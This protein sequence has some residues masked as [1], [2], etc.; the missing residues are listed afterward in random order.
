MSS[1]RRFHW[2]RLQHPLPHPGLAR[3]ARRRR[4]RR[5][6]PQPQER[7]GPRPSSPAS[8]TSALP[9]PTRASRR[10]SPTPPSTPSGSAAPTTPASRTSR[11]SSTPSAAAR[12]RSRASPAR[13][14]SPAT[15]PRRRQCHRARRVGRPQARLPREPA[16]RAARLAGRSL[17]W[18][19]GAATTGRPYL[20]RAAEEHSGPHAPWFWQGAQQGGGVLNDM[21]CHSALVVRHLLT[22]PAKPLSTVRAARITAHIASL[23][24][25]RPE[26]AKRS[27]TMGRT[28]TTR[29]RRP[30]TSR[31]DDRVRDRRR[32]QGDRRGDH[33]LELRG[34]RAAP[35]GRAA[36]PRVLHALELARQRPAALLLAR[37]D[38]A[39]GR[40]PGGEAERRAG[41]DA[42][43]AEE[44]AA[45]GYD[46]HFVRVFRGP[47][48]RAR[49]PGQ[50]GR[51]C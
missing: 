20:A 16:L 29:K 31:R 19:R 15:W 49:L 44:W 51:R 9:S 17:L 14:R 39:R 18:A 38:G 8:S 45:Y 2:L 3:R 1:G 33:E 6:E 36:R 11:R 4:A 47:P 26:Y 24:W 32:P 50:G 23:K 27:R 40:G 46:R 41:G 42:R 10:W 43:G 22:K 21:M 12:A 7:R 13:S 30:R 28:S 37:G 25:S 34:R 35:V 5:L 48:L